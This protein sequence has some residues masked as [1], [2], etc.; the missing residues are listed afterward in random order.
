MYSRRRPRGRR[1]REEEKRESRVAWY[2]YTAREK[3]EE[4]LRQPAGK[5]EMERAVSSA[6]FSRERAA[7]TRPRV[8]YVELRGGV[9]VGGGGG[10]GKKGRRTRYYGFW[11]LG[12]SETMRRSG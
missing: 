11:C 2:Y 1:I 9:I 8:S 12:S 3:R 7:E 6:G 5:H 10:A 4:D